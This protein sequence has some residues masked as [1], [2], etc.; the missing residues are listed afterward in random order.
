M[1]EFGFNIKKSK[2]NDMFDSDRK[3]KLNFLVLNYCAYLTFINLF[4]LFDLEI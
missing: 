4:I 1:A 3:R 2:R